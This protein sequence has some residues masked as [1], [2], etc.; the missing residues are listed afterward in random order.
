M[1][2][3]ITHERHTVLWPGFDSLLLFLQLKTST[4]EWRI[5]KEPSHTF[6]YCLKKSWSSVDYI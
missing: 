6:R 3:G 5:L 2:K 1:Y 4:N